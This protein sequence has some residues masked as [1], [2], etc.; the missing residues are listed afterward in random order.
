LAELDA[1]G[2]LS[3]GSFR[4]PSKLALEALDLKLAL[5][6]GQLTVAPLQAR[7]GGG[8]LEG[9]L[10]VDAMADLP[11]VALDLEGKELDYGRLLRDLDLDSGVE[12]LFDL[13]LAVTGQGFT[14]R[15]IAGSLNGRAQ[16]LSL[17]GTVNHQ[18][19]KAIAVG[20]GDVLAP[21]LGER[22][23]ARLNCLA[24]RFDLSAGR[25]RSR[26]LLL[27]TP[28]VTL[29][30]E[31]QVDLGREQLDLQFDTE[32]REPGLASLTVPFTVTGSL[33][34]PRVTPDPLGAAGNLA[35]GIVS[36]AGSIG[37]LV[38]GEDG[39]RGDA[40]P[41]TLAR[42]ILRQGAPAASATAAPK[43]KAA[44]PAAAGPGTTGGK[45]SLDEALDDF[46]R[47]IK[48]LFD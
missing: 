41:C 48:K 29:V 21:L 9:R 6:S 22:D 2:T 35:G 23:T 26:V 19:M 7:L 32:T 27:D 47:D 8:R 45:K 46:T 10:D 14:P 11:A 43:P 18:A 25:A 39:A 12:G 13:S 16:A 38:T 34:E 30:G 20:L 42:A 28:R 31:G 36:L 1:E 24:G 17:K 40:E 15:A 44:A 4:L 5:N 37:D 3:A 33:S